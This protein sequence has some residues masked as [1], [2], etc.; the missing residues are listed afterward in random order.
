MT[1]GIPPKHSFDRRVIGWFQKS[2]TT[3]NLATAP[4]MLAHRPSSKSLSAE[5]SAPKIE[6][7]AEKGEGEEVDGEQPKKNDQS[8]EKP[9]VA[10]SQVETAPVPATRTVRSYTGGHQS[11]SFADA[12]EDKIAGVVGHEDVG[13]EEEQLQQQQQ[14]QE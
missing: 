5:E 2:G 3:L 9:S 13:E 12:L 8:Q 11:G 7:E 1:S 4:I 10:S 14:Q 6:A